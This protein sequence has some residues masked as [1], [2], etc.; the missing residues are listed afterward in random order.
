MGYG[1]N[2]IWR[3]W[4]D[5]TRKEDELKWDC[6]AQFDCMGRP[7]SS[8]SHFGWEREQLGRVNRVR[9]ALNDSGPMAQ[10]M[11]A[12]RLSGIN[13]SAI[14][15]ILV[16]ACQDIALYYGGSAVAGGV[17]GSF[18]GGVGVVPGAAA[19][20]YVGG[21]VLGMLGLKSLVEG[22]TEAIPDAFRYYEKGFREA[23]GPTRRDHRHGF[24]PNSR[25][26]PFFAAGDL[27]NGH[28]I[29]ISAILT[30]LAA[31]FT[32]GKG[33]IL[34]DIRQSARLGPRVARWAEENED[35]L[36][37]HLAMQSRGGGSL[38]S[39]AP[40]PPIRKL[41]PMK[42]QKRDAVGDSVQNSKIAQDA[43]ANNTASIYLGH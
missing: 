15:H 25:G 21:L 38:P 37:R 29:M 34:K 43:K 27:A 19:G 31:Y 32:R 30:V 28:V 14:W 8:S 26:D 7:A 4:D 5:L 12:D 22:V 42:E 1:V 41:A 9:Q 23:W 33:D 17:V 10:N 20:G 3:V 18:F 24:D 39:A 40:P 16:S 2:D 6:G 11:I 35:K 36:R 13:L